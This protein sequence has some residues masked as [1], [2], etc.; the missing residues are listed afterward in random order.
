[1]AGDG[2][3]LHVYAVYTTDAEME[4]QI[5]SGN[6][7][8]GLHAATGTFQVWRQVD[9]LKR[10]LLRTTSPAA[11]PIDLAPVQAK[12][13]HY[14]V[15][16]TAPAVVHRARGKWYAKLRKVCQGTLGPPLP[17]HI[18]EAIDPTLRT[19]LVPTRSYDDWLA[20]MTHLHGVGNALYTWA[21]NVPNYTDLSGNPVGSSWE[22]YDGNSGLTP[23]MRPWPLAE[24]PEDHTDRGTGIVVIEFLDVGQNVT[25]TFESGGR[26]SHRV[27]DLTQT[28]KDGLKNAISNAICTDLETN[29]GHGYVI[30]SYQ[31]PRATSR[32]DH[33]PLRYRLCGRFVERRHRDRFANVRAALQEAMTALFRDSSKSNYEG[34]ILKL[35]WVFI[36]FDT[37]MSELLD[38]EFGAAKGMVALQV[39]DLSNAQTPAGKAFYA[40]AAGD[41]ALAACLATPAHQRTLEHEIGHAMFLN[42]TYHSQAPSDPNFFHQS[43][44]PSNGACIMHFQPTNGCNDAC[45]FCGFCQARLSGW[46]TLTVDPVADTAAAPRTLYYNADYNQHPGAP[47]GNVPHPITLGVDHD[48]DL[49]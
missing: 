19:H 5:T 17:E 47:G 49:V 42:H 12:F 26:L 45:M 39:Q 31:H 27:D 48:T 8:A 36:V 35:G 23:L 29:F 11:V 32:L 9:M 30:S 33:R 4:G 22:T 41:R 1:M 3:E 25:L 34:T 14:H 28:Q 18:R 46:S 10:W 2:Y 20:R 43:T 40:N 24:D 16:L 37:V 6:I 7:P 15:K 13:E 44:Q 38:A 21:E